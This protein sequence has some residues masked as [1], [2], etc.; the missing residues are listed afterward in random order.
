MSNMPKLTLF[1]EKCSEGL[2]KKFVLLVVKGW[3]YMGL[4]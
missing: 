3:K 1:M 4:T 2:K